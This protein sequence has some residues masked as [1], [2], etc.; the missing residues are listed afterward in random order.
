MLQS[1]VEVDPVVVVVNP[2]PQLTQGA[3]L[4]ETS[5]YFPNGQDVQVGV[6]APSRN[7]LSVLCEGVIVSR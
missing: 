5:L 4:E 3:L 2:L 6:V 1:E 7:S